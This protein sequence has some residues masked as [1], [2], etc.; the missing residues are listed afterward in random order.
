MQ[1][2]EYQVQ[3]RLQ[4]HSL[5]YKQCSTDIN[6]RLLKLQKHVATAQQSSVKTSSRLQSTY[7]RPQHNIMPIVSKHPEISGLNQVVGSAISDQFI[8]SQMKSKPAVAE[9]FED[10]GSKHHTTQEL[11]GKMKEPGIFTY[12][13]NKYGTPRTQLQNLSEKGC[14][15]T[16]AIDSSGVGSGPMLNYPV[17]A[18]VCL[19]TPRHNFGPNISCDQKKKCTVNTDKTV[20]SEVTSVALPTSRIRGKLVYATGQETDH[21]VIGGLQFESRFESG[22]LLKAIRL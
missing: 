14:Y 7:S 20:F 13:H 18:L 19:P 3:L 6:P 10:H 5:Y 1:D 12:V 16:I 17:E 21:D 11:Y 9:K 15:E 2:L 22:N 8:P 4:I